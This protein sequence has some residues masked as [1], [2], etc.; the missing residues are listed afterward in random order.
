MTLEKRQFGFWRNVVSTPAGQL[1]GVEG[2]IAVTVGVAAAIWLAREGTRDGRIAIAGDFLTLSSALV[3]VV[4]A[5]FA[6]VI[7]LLS[8]K[9]LVLLERSSGGT[10]VFLAPFIINIGAQVFV[11]IGTVGYRAAAK[12]VPLGV[13]QWIFGVVAVFFIY[14]TLNIVA[15]ARN[16]LAH[17]ATRAEQA[18]IEELKRVVEAKR[19][20]RRD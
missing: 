20:V 4:F 10:R 5:G 12:Q 14:A 8:D 16:V 13:E 2:V 17:G 7:A 6:L 3:G 19:A 18:T 15:L 9:Y 11:V 1:I